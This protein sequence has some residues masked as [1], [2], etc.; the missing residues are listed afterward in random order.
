MHRIISLFLTA[1]TAILPMLSSAVLFYSTGDNT[2]NTS[3]PT[4]T[5]TNSGWQYQGTFLQYLGTPIAPHHFITASHFGGSVGNTFSFNGTTYTTISKITDPGSDLVLYEID[6]TFPFYAPIYSQSDEVNKNFVVFGRGTQRGAEVLVNGDLKGWQW[7]VYDYVMRWGENKVDAI[8]LVNGSETLQADF[9][10]SGGLGVNEC[11]LSDKD[12]GGGIFIKDGGDWKLAGINYAINP[13]HFSFSS[14]ASDPFYAALFDYSFRPSN[15]EKLYYDDGSPPWPYLSSNGTDP[16]RFY[17]TRIS[18]RYT[19]ITNNIPD[20]DR[21]VD[22]LPDWW[23]TLYGGDPTSMERNGLSD[24]DAFTNYE[25]WLAD[26]IPTDSSS[27]L[28]V[29]G[30]SNLTHLIFNSSSERVYQVEFRT[31]LTDT[32]ESWQVETGGDWSEGDYPQTIRPVS[33]VSTQRYHRVRAKPR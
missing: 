25:E 30:Y 17:S 11:M 19:W 24:S 2:F 26:T 23:E 14:T 8:A 1:G 12:S 16:C 7:G 27:F 31:D 3:E 9:D 10:S 15:A 29:T 32:N 5:L 13:A 20:F 6:G 22:G 33:N 21:D 4:G 28:R 18:S